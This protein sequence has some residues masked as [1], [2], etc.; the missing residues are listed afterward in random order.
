MTFVG[1]KRFKKKLVLHLELNK[2]IMNTKIISGKNKSS[3]NLIYANKLHVS[4]SFGCDASKKYL[5]SLYKLS[6]LGQLKK[7]PSLVTHYINDNKTKHNFTK[8]SS[9]AILYSK[10]HFIFRLL[11]FE[12]NSFFRKAILN[13]VDL[14]NDFFNSFALNLNFKRNRFFPFLH[15]NFYKVVILNNSLGVI[16][17][18][19]SIKKSFLKSKNSYM[20]S[21]VYLRRILIYT[22][23]N[24][25]HL[26]VVRTP[27]FLKEIMNLILE[28]SDILYK[29]PFKS[30]HVNESLVKTSMNFTYINFIKSKSVSPIK[31][32]KKAD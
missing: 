1:R 11:S 5:F 24:N 16:S 9:L 15:M 27:K 14:V 21:A 3:L 12:K 6:L 32:K 30:T 4:L 19:F 13:S 26:N 10:V 7:N 28:G 20:L 25:Y 17:N 18:Y 23:I 8:S 22:G 29:H 31:R 2:F